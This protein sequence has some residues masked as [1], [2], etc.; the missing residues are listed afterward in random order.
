MSVPEWIRSTPEYERGLF[1]FD[2]DSKNLICFVAYYL[3]ECFVRNYSQLR[4]ATGN[5]EY[6]EANMPVV[7]GFKREI[8]L[9]PML[10][11]ENL[12]RRITAKP[13]R[14]SDIE[15]AIDTWRNYLK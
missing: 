10:V 7:T 14:I 4:W 3:G 12:F 11:L 9:A 13:D 1:E 5:A 6:A 8:E 15:I 2:E